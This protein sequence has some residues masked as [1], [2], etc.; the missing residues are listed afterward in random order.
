LGGVILWPWA[1]RRERTVDDER[2]AELARAMRA[3]QSR[4]YRARQLGRVSRL[5]RPG[6]V[7]IDHLYARHGTLAFLMEV[8]GGPPLAEPRRWLDPFAWYNARA[9][10]IAVDAA[11]AALALVEEPFPD[12]LARV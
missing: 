5:F 3:R 6:G 12:A 4:P 11:R 9:P 2:F 10:E 1:S 8:R 7:E